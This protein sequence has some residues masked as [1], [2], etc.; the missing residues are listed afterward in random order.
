LYL[1]A[2]ETTVYSLIFF[3]LSV[4]EHT[5]SIMFFNEDTG[6]FWYQLHLISEPSPPVLLPSVTC[7]VGKKTTQSVTIENPT[8]SDLVL[9]INNSNPQ[10]F[11]V[12]P[13]MMIEFS[14]NFH[15]ILLAA[16]IVVPPFE[17]FDV[18]IVYSPSS[19]AKEETARK[20]FLVEFS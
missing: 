13:G 5:G 15:N 17:K 10:N 18:Q 2:K 11:Q 7:E 3:P 8:E 1:D 9:Q 19:I 4:G 6:E 12:L 14:W 20:Y 16:K